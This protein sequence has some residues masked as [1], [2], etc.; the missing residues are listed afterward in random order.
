M[1]P[2]CMHQRQVMTCASV[3]APV[4]PKS[5]P[6]HPSTSPNQA[7][8]KCKIVIRI[9]G[10]PS[11]TAPGSRWRA[12]STPRINP[13]HPLVRNSTVLRIRLLSSRGPLPPPRRRRVPPLCRAIA[14]SKPLYAAGAA[15]QSSIAGI[16]SLNDTSGHADTD[17]MPLNLPPPLPHPS[18]EMALA[19][20]LV[21]IFNFYDREYRTKSFLMHCNIVLLNINQ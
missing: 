9:R 15:S 6:P 20:R 17:L 13:P 10:H 11:T 12:P 5:F 1:W 14:S 2:A 8:S 7:R 3:A 21:H 4:H 18:T 16:H 19:A